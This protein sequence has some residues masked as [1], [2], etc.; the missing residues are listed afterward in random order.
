MRDSCPCDTYIYI[1]INICIYIYIYIYIYSVTYFFYK[2]DDIL[3]DLL[4][5]SAYMGKLTSEEQIKFVKYVHI[6]A[7]AG[8][9]AMR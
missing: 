8:I 9:T 5:R 1:Y 2:Q 7:L 3:A 4:K 6:L